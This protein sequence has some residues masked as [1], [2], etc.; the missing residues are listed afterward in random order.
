MNFMKNRRH[1]M[2]GVPSLAM[3]GLVLGACASVPA[4]P[5]AQLQAA[6]SA[7]ATADQ[8]RVAD[9][10]SPELTEA[11]ENLASARE[12]VQKQDMVGARRLAELSRAD[13]ELAYAKAGQR[14]AQKVNEEMKKS[15]EALKSEMQ[16]N[17]GA[18]R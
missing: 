2:F 9:D 14:K 3:T 17:T 6:E 16:R 7:I 5:T 4:P 11:R 10:L 15:T 12:A 1:A 8:A 13:A 18:T